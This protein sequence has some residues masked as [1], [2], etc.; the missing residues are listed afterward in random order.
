MNSTGLETWAQTC[1]TLPISLLVGWGHHTGVH[2]H[3]SQWGTP[4]SY[5]WSAGQQ[6]IRVLRTGVL[7]FQKDLSSQGCPFNIAQVEGEGWDWRHIWHPSVATK[8]KFCGGTQWA[9]L[10]VLA[11]WGGRVR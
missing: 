3:K 10:P 8:A 2:P 1:A 6:S 11:G 9:T 4:N 5:S 7:C